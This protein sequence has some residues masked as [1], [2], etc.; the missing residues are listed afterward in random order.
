M[1]ASLAPDSRTVSYLVCHALWCS[2]APLHNNNGCGMAR[3]TWQELELQEAPRLF[4]RCSYE[5]V[6]CPQGQV[7]P[8]ADHQADGPLGEGSPYGT[9]R[10]LQ[11]GRG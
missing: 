3:D 11:G 1:A 9:V 7:Y 5:E 6:R 2:R 10:E 4:P 8:G